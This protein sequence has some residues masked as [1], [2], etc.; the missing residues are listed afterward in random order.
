MLVGSYTNFQLISSFIVILLITPTF[1][2]LN[3]IFHKKD[4]ALVGQERVLLSNKANLYLFL[5]SFGIISFVLLI[6][7][8][9][10]V[11]MYF[12]LFITTFVYGLA[13]AKRKMYLSYF[14]R[15]MSGV[16]TFLLYYSIF[17]KEIQSTI[18]ITIVVGLYDL[19]GNIAGDLRDC[20]KDLK[21]GVITLVTKFDQDYAIKVMIYLTVGIYAILGSLIKIELVLQLFFMN[22]LLYVLIDG[23][24]V[25]Y[26]H[27]LI[28]GSKCLF[29]ICLGGIISSAMN[30]SLVINLGIIS[31]FWTFAYNLYLKHNI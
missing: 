8:L 20:E 10:S 27:G 29:F 3:D 11:L 2:L 9:I 14:G 23:I 4:D 13:K 17:N 26:R 15:Y 5:S 18:L 7:S 22:M 12:F 30:M 25:K 16:V 24:G 28:H 19:I 6:N 1:L 21:A 31:S